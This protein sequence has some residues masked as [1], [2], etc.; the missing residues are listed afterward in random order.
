VAEP[1]KVIPVAV[2]DTELGIVWV[3]SEVELAS[4]EELIMPLGPKV[5]PRSVDDGASEEADVVGEATIAPG[6]LPVVVGKT[7]TPGRPP[8]EPTLPASE[9]VPG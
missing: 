8:V 1:E 4:A 7:T 2:S 3:R 9:L 6:T 5:I